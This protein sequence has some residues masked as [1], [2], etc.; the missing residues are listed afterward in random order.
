M[1]YREEG[2]YLMLAGGGRKLLRRYLIDTGIPRQE[3]DSLPL[4]ADGS[5]IM[6]VIGGR[7]SEYYKIT[8]GT[9]RVLEVRIGGHHE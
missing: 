1:R 2:D 5:H 3:R 6:W 7:I 4:L 9:R 8:S